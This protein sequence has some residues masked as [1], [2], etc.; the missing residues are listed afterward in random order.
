MQLTEA[1]KR[2]VSSIKVY[3]PKVGHVKKRVGHVAETLLDDQFVYVFGGEI[4][5]DDRVP[6]QDALLSD[7]VRVRVADSDGVLLNKLQWEI[8]PITTDLDVEGGEN[9]ESKSDDAAPKEQEDEDGADSS[10]TRAVP[11]ASL[12]LGV[13]TLRVKLPMIEFAIFGG[14]NTN[15]P[16][17][18]LCVF[19][20]L[21][22]M[23]QCP[24]IT[25]KEPSPRYRH[26][27]VAV[28]LAN[29]PPWPP[30]EKPPVL[31]EEGVVGWRMKSKT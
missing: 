19:D 29:P 15:Q 2:W 3:D 16:L 5:G 14:F 31:H 30:L 24:N 11:I 4:I 26:N 13:G 28:P 21:Q 27:M 6:G 18:N 9:K 17:S 12:S 23:W 8:V 7:T 20:A 10:N 22:S 1:K 25:G